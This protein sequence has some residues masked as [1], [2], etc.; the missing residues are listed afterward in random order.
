MDLMPIKNKE[1]IKKSKN[2]C[3]IGKINKKEL[4]YP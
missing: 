2:K 1:L 3:G 4:H